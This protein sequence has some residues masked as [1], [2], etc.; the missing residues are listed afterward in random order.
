MLSIH[1]L[2]GVDALRKG[3]VSLAGR[4]PVRAILGGIMKKVGLVVLS[5]ATALATAPAAMA[6]SFDFVVNGNAVTSGQNC[7]SPSISGSGVLT[8]VPDVGS[9]GAFDITSGSGISFTIGSTIYNAS[10]IGNEENP[11]APIT[12][13]ADPIGDA[14]GAGNFNFDDLLMPAGNPL[15][16]ANG[17]LFELTSPGT[18]DGATLELYSDGPNG[19]SNEIWWDLYLKGQ[20]DYGFPFGAETGGYGAP[21]D[22][23]IAPEPSSLLLLGTGLLLMACFLF[24]F[25]TMQNTI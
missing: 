7:C 5:L 23:E 15:V 25:K 9:P 2:Q 19:P 12:A 6:D 3:E 17:I 11:L 13:E 22:M 21:L 16:D 4:L 8:G 18:Y 1:L 20:T 24:R 10:L 14:L